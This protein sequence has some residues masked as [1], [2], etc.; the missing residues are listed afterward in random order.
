[1]QKPY[2][3]FC[4]CACRKSFCYPITL[5]LNCKMLSL[6]SFLIFSW[7][8]FF[9][10]FGYIIPFIYVRERALENK[11][12]ISKADWLIPTLGIS[13]SIGRVLTILVPPNRKITAL[14]F[15]SSMLVICGLFTC[16]SGI[17]Q[18]MITP[19]QFVY[20]AVYGFCSGKTIYY[21]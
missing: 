7:I 9:S 1:M 19:V 14:T 17:E 20:C 8:G 15:M 2:N 12:H 21:T 16:V 10:N 18:L 6:P 13:G 5:M 3:Y 11:I 4:R